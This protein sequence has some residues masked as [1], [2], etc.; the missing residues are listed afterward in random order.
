MNKHQEKILALLQK[1]MGTNPQRQ[2]LEI[3]FIAHVPKMLRTW[4]DKIESGEITSKSATIL[5]DYNSP[6]IQKI[7]IVTT[8]E[9]D[10]TSL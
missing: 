8:I 10:E 5:Y 7:S 2:L 4:A 3:D 6:D 1:T 9:P